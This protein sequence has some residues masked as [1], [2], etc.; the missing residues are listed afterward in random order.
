M[1]SSKKQS[2]DTIEDLAVE[3][4]EL[5]NYLETHEPT[6]HDIDRLAHIEKIIK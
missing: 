2:H 3:Y 4:I 5:L 1:K 6:D